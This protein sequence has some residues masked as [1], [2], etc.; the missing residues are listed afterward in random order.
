MMMEVCDGTSI[1]AFE[2][3]ARVRHRRHRELVGRVQAHEIHRETRKL[4]AVPYKVYWDD[5]AKAC[6]V[7]GWMYLYPPHESLERAPA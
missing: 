5:D 7:L 3:G 1:D 6:A 2:V 4:S